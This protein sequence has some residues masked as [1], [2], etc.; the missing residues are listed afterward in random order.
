MSDRRN[1]PA[2]EEVSP[3]RRSL[4]WVVAVMAMVAILYPKGKGDHLPSLSERVAGME[5]A[6]LLTTFGEPDLRRVEGPSAHWQ[7]VS[8]TCILDI[9]LMGDRV[10]YIDV[11]ARHKGKAAD[12]PP[13]P[14][15]KNLC[16]DSQM[17]T[18]EQ[19]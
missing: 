12:M 3:L 6:T 11:R 5:S 2:A 17:K 16:I 13:P 9:F 10:R 4:A 18:S 8:E 1:I 15:D 7:Y 19:K 14:P